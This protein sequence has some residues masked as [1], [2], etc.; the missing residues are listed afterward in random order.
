MYYLTLKT[1]VNFVTFQ[2]IYKHRANYFKIIY[3]SGLL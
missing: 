1:T 2:I 3:Y